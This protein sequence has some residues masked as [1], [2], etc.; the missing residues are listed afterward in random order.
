VTLSDHGAPD[1][2]ELLREAETDVRGYTL[3]FEMQEVAIGQARQVDP[4][5]VRGDTALYLATLQG[6]GPIAG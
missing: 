5:A 1:D 3:L 4:T 6:F 2:G